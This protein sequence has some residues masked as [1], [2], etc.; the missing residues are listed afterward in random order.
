MDM[1]LVPRKGQ[2]LARM[3]MLSLVPRMLQASEQMK[4]YMSGR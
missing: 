1:Q 2:H 4:R 3:R